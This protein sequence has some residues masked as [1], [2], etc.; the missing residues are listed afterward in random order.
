MTLSVGTTFVCYE[1]DPPLG[2][3]GMVESIGC[4]TLDLTAKSPS[5]F[6]LKHS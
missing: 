2:A 4:A 1:I 6:C 5:N 3:G